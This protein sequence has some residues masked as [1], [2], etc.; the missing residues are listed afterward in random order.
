M[1]VEVSAGSAVPELRSV[2]GKYTGNLSV[3]IMPKIQMIY[4]LPVS[5]RLV[6]QFRW[7]R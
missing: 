7:N 6:W 1:K 2:L 4:K 5:Q 3:A